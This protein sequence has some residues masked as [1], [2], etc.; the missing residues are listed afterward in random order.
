MRERRLLQGM[1]HSLQQEI[2]KEREAI[3]DE[4]LQM[5][6]KFKGNRYLL[7]KQGAPRLEVSVT[8]RLLEGKRTSP[9]TGSRSCPPIARGVGG[10]LQRVA[11]DHF[12]PPAEER[13]QEGKSVLPPRGVATKVLEAASA[14]ALSLLG[15]AWRVLKTASSWNRA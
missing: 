7:E 15:A 9:V 6:E 8:I 1:I 2:D 11:R 4:D 10:G 13:T 3:K 5:E 14:W 12:E